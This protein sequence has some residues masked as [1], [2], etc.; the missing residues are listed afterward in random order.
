LHR[1]L[2]RELLTLLHET[3]HRAAPLSRL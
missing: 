1:M 2:T 3:F